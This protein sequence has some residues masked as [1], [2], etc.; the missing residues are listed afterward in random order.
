MNLE[1][2]IY[3]LFGLIITSV[4]NPFAAIMVLC[5]LSIMMF[6]DVSSVYQLNISTR[7]KS[8]LGLRSFSYVIL[9]GLFHEVDL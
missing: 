4:G 3:G 7:S 8:K 9:D 5:S 2:V 1:S 6:S